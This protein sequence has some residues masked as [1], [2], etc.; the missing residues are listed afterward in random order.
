M[1]S[2]FDNGLLCHVNGTISGLS[3][4]I[5]E[6]TYQKKTCYLSTGQ[7]FCML[8]ILTRFNL[9]SYVTSVKDNLSNQPT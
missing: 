3:A 6:A 7:L 2:A 4:Y 9:Y 8:S 1:M 5:V